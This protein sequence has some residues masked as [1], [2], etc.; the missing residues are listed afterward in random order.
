MQNTFDDEKSRLLAKYH[1]GTQQA[2][3]NAGF[4]C[5]P[6]ITVLQAYF[7]YLVSLI[8][9]ALPTFQ[10][11][12]IC[13]RQYVD[14]ARPLLPDRHRRAR[15]PA[16]GTAPRRRPVPP[17]AVRG[18]DPPPPVVAA[19]LLR[20]A[21]R[22]DHGA[23]QSRPC[24]PA[25]PTPSGPLNIND[26]DLHLNAKDPPTPYVGP[27]EMLFCLTGI[28]MITAAPPG[29]DRDKP[30]TVNN[31]EHTR[32]FHYSPS[33]SSPDVVTPRGQPG[34]AYRHRRL[35]QLH[36]EHVPHLKMCDPK[37][38]LHF[39]T[40]MMTRQALC[41]LRVINFLVRNSPSHQQQQHQQQQQQQQGGGPGSSNNGGGPGGPGG[42][43]GPMQHMSPSGPPAHEVPERDALFTE[44]IRMIEYDNIMQSAESLR[45]FAWYT[46]MHFPFPGYMFIVS[47]LRWRRTGELAERAWAAVA[48][49]H[50][51]RGLIR[52]LR[53]PIHVAFGPLFVKAWDAREAAELQ[54]GRAVQAPKFVQLLRQTLPKVTIPS[55]TAG[56]RAPGTNGTTSR[57]AS[58]GA[59]PPPATGVMGAP[60]TGG[61]HHRA[62]V[63]D[64]SSSS[65][66][67]VGGE[68]VVMDDQVM[69]GGFDGMGHPMMG[70]PPG[71]GRHGFW[72]DGLVIPHAEHA[73]RRRVRR[74][75]S[76]RGHVFAWPPGAVDKKWGVGTSWDELEGV[77]RSWGR[78]FFSFRSAN[79]GLAGVVKLLAGW[80][81]LRSPECHVPWDIREGKR[82]AA[83]AGATGPATAVFY[84]F[85]IPFSRHR[86]GLPSCMI[87]LHRAAP[88]RQL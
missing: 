41:K 10:Q 58:A 67:G 51:R 55:T 83:T 77:G 38:P 29:G 42:G 64:T 12:Q 79:F 1:R 27:T 75:R 52:N 7:L 31:M 35:L 76:L 86:H 73:R 87:L 50:E 62:S 4:M 88:L 25:A 32:K 69:Y 19:V 70:G 56:S 40:L 20:Q 60:G 46:Y 84:F 37:I 34:A 3:I 33:P 9:V 8:P 22:R 68:E 28:E 61:H 36:R 49:N 66:G 59:A 11:S 26:T 24:R 78:E 63:A 13:V 30:N 54:L 44:A 16:T 39:F 14:P 45:G 53:S 74:L 71:M 21:H 72:P 85:F 65:M 23:P 6:D 18:R 15:C 47:E 81:D 80:P 57:S 48:E 17:A 43:L 2:L 82:F 5:S